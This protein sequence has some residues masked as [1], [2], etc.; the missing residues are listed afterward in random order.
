[1]WIVEVNG[2]GS[3]YGEDDAGIIDA[4]TAYGYRPFRYAAAD[5]QLLAVD[6]AR[7]AGGPNLIFARDP[8]DLRGRLS[9]G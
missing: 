3:R 6:P 8:A 2:F 9:H 7:P 4:L 1:V 5:N